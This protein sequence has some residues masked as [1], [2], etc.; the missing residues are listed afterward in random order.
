MIWLQK[1]FV[2]ELELEASGEYSIPW[3]TKCYTSVQEPYFSI[4]DQNIWIVRLHWIRDVLETK[5]VKLDK[6]H[7]DESEGDMMTNA[8]FKELLDFCRSLDSMIKAIFGWPRT[9]Q[10]SI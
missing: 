8:L 4:R 1:F 2:A 5:L 3:W 6:V 10:V 7:I 9:N